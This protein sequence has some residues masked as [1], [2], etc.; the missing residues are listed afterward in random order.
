M[1]CILGF[2]CSTASAVPLCVDPCVIHTDLNDLWRSVDNSINSPIYCDQ[3][4]NF[5]GWYRLFLGQTS[6]QIPEYCV[7]QNKCGTHGPLW[8]NGT[9]PT[10][11][12]QIVSRSVCTHFAGDCCKYPKL[13]IQIKLCPGPFYVY[14]LVKPDNCDTA[15]CT[16]TVPFLLSCHCTALTQ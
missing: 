4:V 10:Q 7:D 6:A 15:Y 12:N 1:N 8:L 3:N 2:D 5:Q 9:H 11:L 14:K 13:T 16:G